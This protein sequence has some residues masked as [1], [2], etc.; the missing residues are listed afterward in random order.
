M[1][2]RLALGRC[3]AELL[4]RV[5]EEALVIGPGAREVGRSLVHHRHLQA[6]GVGLLGPRDIDMHAIQAT[7]TIRVEGRLDPQVVLDPRLLVFEGLDDLGLAVD[8]HML[9]R[10]GRSCLSHKE[11]ECEDLHSWSPS[12]VHAPLTCSIRR[13]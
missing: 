1:R 2:H 12:L 8:D 11:S 5:P 4:V 7:I 13:T 3:C 10:S 9:G 6:F